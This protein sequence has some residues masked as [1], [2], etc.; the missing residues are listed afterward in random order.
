M[1]RHGL[2]HDALGSAHETNETPHL[3]VALSALITFFVPAAVSLS[4]INAFDA[5]GYFGTLCSFGFLLVY[6]LVSVAAPIYLRSL[7]QLGKADILYSVLGCGFMLL[8]LFGTIGIPGS[9]LFPPPAYPN[10]LLVW[11]FVVY[12]A[13]GLVWLLTQ[14]AR[15]PKM[16]PTMKISMDELT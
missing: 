10:N 6:I 1:A 16:L 9:T 12:M 3:A 15:S 14:K 4:G 2:F 8:P 13:V 7:G 5:Q 11:I